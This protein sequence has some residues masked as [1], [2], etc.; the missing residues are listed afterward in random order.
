MYKQ[1]DAQKSL[2]PTSELYMHNNKE[3]CKQF[4]LQLIRNLYDSF[5]TPD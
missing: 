5:I 1:I 3:W 4:L 2:F